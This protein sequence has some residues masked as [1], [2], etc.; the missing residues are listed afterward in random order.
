M[1]AGDLNGDGIPDVVI[2]NRID[3][4]V[5]VFLGNGDGTFLPAKNLRNRTAGVARH[6]GRRQR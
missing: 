4:T 3:D 5:S 1:A 6:R 2:A